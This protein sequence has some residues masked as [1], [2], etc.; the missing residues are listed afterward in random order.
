LIAIS[1]ERFFA[2]KRY[3]V[4]DGS[5]FLE[6]GRPLSSLGLPKDLPKLDAAFVWGKNK[7]TYFFA[8]E[9]YWKYDEVRRSIVKGYPAHIR[10]W[11]GIPENLDSVLTWIDGVTYFFRSG[12][13][14]RFNDGM[15]IADSGAIET[16]PHWFGCSTSHP[17]RKG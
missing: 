3:W 9:Q 1:N 15:V 6:R 11:R 7:H 13:F 14:W 4:S 16:A 2:G 8:G 17:M 5:S 12:F 10:A